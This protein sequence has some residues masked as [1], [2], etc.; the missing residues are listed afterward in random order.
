MTA[1][2]SRIALLP[3]PPYYS[4][5]FISQRTADDGE[6]YDRMA[7][8]MAQLAA[9]QP[10]FLGM[11]SVRDTSGVGITLAYFRTQA[12]VIA[13][14]HVTAHAHAQKLGRERWYQDYAVRIAKVERAYTMATSPQ[15]G[16]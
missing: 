16:L 2:P 9:Q 13:W 8:A 11:E 3:E 5:L 14:K 6:D 4:V 7:A 15:V 12:D 10:G 1:T